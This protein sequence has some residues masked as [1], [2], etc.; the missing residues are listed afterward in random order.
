MADVAVFG[1]LEES[2]AEDDV[3]LRAVLADDGHRKDFAAFCEEEH[4][5]ENIR[6]WEA[7][8]QFRAAPESTPPP[9]DGTVAAGGAGGAAS[10]PASGA[11]LSRSDV[12]RRIIRKFVSPHAPL[13]VN[14]EDSMREELARAVAGECAVSTFD[15]CEAI[16]FKQLKADTLKRY[17]LTGRFDDYIAR[18]VAH[19]DSPDTL[20]LASS[21]GDATAEVVDLPGPR[22]QAELA[23][24]LRKREFLG[25]KIGRSHSKAEKQAFV[26]LGASIRATS[27]KAGF[28]MKRGDKVQNWQRRW[29][30]ISLTVLGYFLDEFQH[31]P[32]RVILNSEVTAIK[33][34]MDKALG[35]RFAFALE[36]KGRL[37][38][39]QA[40]NERDRER[41][42]E[43]LAAV[44]NLGVRDA[45][46]R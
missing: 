30:V 28:V 9:A 2:N 42:L 34:N 3:V 45:A 33:S 10:S 16:V 15:V 38:C 22:E 35:M 40:A 11:T 21:F 37:Y 26:R 27:I 23:Q 5:E 17:R 44:L 43:A 31:A 41:W 8:Q 6:F 12:G 18:S 20:A 32:K 13:K 14:M 46:A 19:V 36:T 29:F 25:F 7:I 1:S 4:S 39:F 24:L